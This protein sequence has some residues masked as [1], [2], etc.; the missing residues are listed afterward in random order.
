MNK[1]LKKDICE[2]GHKKGSHQQTQRR[3]DKYG[4]CLIKGCSC[5]KFKPACSGDENEKNL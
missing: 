1:P 4:Y 3:K 2:C 5:K